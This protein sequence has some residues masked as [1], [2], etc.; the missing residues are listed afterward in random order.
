MALSQAAQN[1][2]PTNAEGLAKPL[3]LKIVAKVMST[4]Y[5]EIHDR[6]INS[7]TGKIDML[8]LIKLVFIKYM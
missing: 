8:N 3:K 1:Q 4:V 5:I 2:K 6:L 7:Q